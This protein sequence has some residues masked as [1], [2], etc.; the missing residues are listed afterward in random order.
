MPTKNDRL[1]IC[2]MGIDGS[3][4]TS[5]AIELC[6]R[7][8]ALSLT[9]RYIHHTFSLI[10]YLPPGLG[11]ALRRSASTSSSSSPGHKPTWKEG[12]SK[13]KALPIL[14][15]L[16]TAINAVIGY[17]LQT[18]LRGGSVIVYDRYFYDNFV[19]Y[20]PS[21]PA[22]LMKLSLSLIPSPDL[23]LFLSVSE[24]VAHQRKAEYSLEDCAALKK[25]Y[26]D[27]INKSNLE[28]L[29][30]VDADSDMKE[31]NASVFSHVERLLNIPTH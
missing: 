9:C 3:G 7:L 29:V 31:V 8:E 25:N 17:I 10:E 27:F 11:E 21:C 4:K 16:L 15:C 26:V 20:S 28:N 6:K 18:G 23:I 22:W 30:V 12:R 24:T 1:T 13:V 5:C 14:F 2:F 19:P